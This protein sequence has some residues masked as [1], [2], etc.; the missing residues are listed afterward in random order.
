[1]KIRGAMLRQIGPAKPYE[2]SG[3]LT[4]E[5]LELAPPGPGEV[6]LE[7]EAAGLCHS[8]LSVVDGVRPRPVPMLLG[9]EA[10]G[11]VVGLGDGVD[12][13]SIGQRVV[14]SYLPACNDCVGCSS[15]GRRPCVPGSA[16]NAAGELL[17]GGRRL[18]S[19]GDPVNHHLGVS[20]FATHAVVDVRSVVP[21]PEDVPAEVA[22]LMGC[23]VLTGGGAVVN[24]GLVNPGEAVAVVGLGGVGL[25]AVLVAK[26]VGA[27]E[28]VAVDPQPDKRRI[29]EDL[30]AT[31]GLHPDETEGLQV[32]CAIEAAGAA[33][34]VNVA[35][36]AT[37]PG[38]RAV[39]VGLTAP[40]VNVP[41]SPLDLVAGGRSVVG[42]YMGSSVPA[43]DVPRFLTLWR[44]GRL[45]VERLISGRIGLNDLNQALDDLAAAR[46]LRQC[47]LPQA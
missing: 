46:V 2:Q 29:A 32:D 37:A 25:A 23:A 33:A 12:D 19:G 5:E 15:G 16:A 1:M 13:I 8:D 36:A 38:G 45:P 35:I 7:I 24:A 20:A 30:G 44:Q 40:G 4:V 47:V 26:A 21:V 34:A 10:A 6:L 22:A 17:R 41:V 3:P 27:R 9:H 42:S 39:L 31:R 11:R 18:S 14:L 28:I 43:R